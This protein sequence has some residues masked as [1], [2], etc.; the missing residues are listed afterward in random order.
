MSHDAY[1]FVA[2]EDDGTLR[3]NRR[4]SDERSCLIQL[5]GELDLESA[6]NL[7]AEVSAALEQRP[8]PAHI[9]VDLADVTFVDSLGLG[10]LIVGHRIC[11]QLGVRLTVRNPSPFVAELI[12]LSGFSDRLIDSVR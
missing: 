6:V 9:Q 7:R 4:D 2:S 3:I 5:V 8:M 11:A 10:T 12:E 1:P